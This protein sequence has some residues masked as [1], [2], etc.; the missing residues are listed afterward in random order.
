MSLKSLKSLGN[1][2]GVR[3]T[4]WYATLFILSGLALFGLTYVLL[5]SSL[6]HKDHESMLAK[7]RDL[8]A[9]YQVAGVEGLKQELAFQ[10]R[11]QQTRPF[12]SALR[13]RLIPHSSSTSRITGLSS[14]CDDWNRGRSP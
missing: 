13:P 4:V 1:T 8:A 12:L 10:D 14:I 7:L 9:Q 3:L 11:L 6:Q 5:A 2:I